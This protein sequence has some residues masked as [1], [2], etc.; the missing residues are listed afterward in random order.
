MHFNHTGSS[1][2]RDR[3]QGGEMD[4]VDHPP[5]SCTARHPGQRPVWISTRAGNA[6]SKTRT[7]VV[8]LVVGLA[9]VLLG[10]APA[11]ATFPGKKCYFVF[12]FLRC[13]SN[14]G[15]ANFEIYT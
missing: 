9:V 14:N 2:H 10:A 5:G 8:C 12:S 4:N 7:M 3:E 13:S 1:R 6:M 15:S 11:S